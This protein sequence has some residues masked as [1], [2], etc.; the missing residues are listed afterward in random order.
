MADEKEP[1]VEAKAEPKMPGTEGAEGS[2]P[3][4]NPGGLGEFLFQFLKANPDIARE[5]STRMNAVINGQK[6]QGLKG[7]APG[8]PPGQAPQSMGA[9]PAQP[10]AAP[11]Q[12]MAGDVLPMPGE[13]SMGGGETPNAAGFATG[14]QSAPNVQS[15]GTPTPQQW[16]AN[17]KAR[18]G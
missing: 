4:G 6:L 3:G 15:I 7:P 2:S 16:L 8:G 9:P 10:G 13:R 17:V 1:K 11:P 5:M 18:Q 12:Q 14:Q